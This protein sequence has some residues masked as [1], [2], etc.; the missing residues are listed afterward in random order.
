MEEGSPAQEAGLRAGDLITHIN[1]ESVL[2]LVHMDVVEL[3]LKVR[4]V[5]PWPKHVPTAHLGCSPHPMGFCSRRCPIPGRLSGDWCPLTQSG[6]KIS[7]RTTA[8]EN[9]SIKVGPARKN[10]AKGRMARR[11][12]RS[13]RRETQDR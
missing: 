5:D 8:L 12:K 6:N 7:L 11:N 3:L 9:T 10:T 13:R 4:P 1:G 2:G